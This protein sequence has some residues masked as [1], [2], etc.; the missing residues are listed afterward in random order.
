MLPLPYNLR[1][2]GEGSIV[3]PGDEEWESW[4][5]RFDNPLGARQ[6]IKIDIESVQTSCG[7]GVPLAET[8]EERDTLR[9]WAIKKGDDGVKSYWKEKNQTSLDGYPTYIVDKNSA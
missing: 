7:F 3:H 1:I 2:I 6:I 9:K 5:S 8:M 4:T